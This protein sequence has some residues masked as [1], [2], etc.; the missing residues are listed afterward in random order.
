MSGC[1][2]DGAVHRVPN[3]EVTTVP[4]TGDVE[5]WRPAPL[6]WMPCDDAPSYDCATLEVPLD[7]NDPGGA[8]VPLAMTRARATGDRIGSLFMNPGGPGGSGIQ[9]LQAS[10]FDKRLT[11]RFD[12]VSWDPRGVGAS[13]GL[14][15]A[16]DGTVERF[17]ANDPSPDTIDEL[18]ALFGDAEAIARKCSAPGTPDAGLLT[19]IGTTDVARDLEA[20]RIAVGDERLTYLGFSYGTHI[21]QR[22]LQLY[23]E[24]VR[25]MVLDGVVDPTQS[26]TEWLRSQALAFEASLGRIFDDCDDACPLEDAAAAYDELHDR[27]EREPIAAGDDALGPARLETAAVYASYSP[28][29]WDRFLDGVADAL[30]GDPSTLLSLARQYYDFG[31]F[32]SYVSVV[33][34]DGEHPEGTDEYAAFIGDLATEAPRLGAMI[35]SELAACA[36]WPVEPDPITEP[37]TGE[38]APPVLVVGT[39]GDAATPYENARRVAHHLA[40]GVL[41]THVGEGHTAYGRESCV[42]SVVDD[43]LVDLVVPDRDPRCGG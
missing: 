20:M 14:T 35:A 1:G 9:F 19:H 21:G 39:T 18:E 40:S 23:P 41:V 25:A 43:Y 37:V 3:T 27:V 33:C 34:R 11:E 15:C 13:A 30:D 26:L 12:L 24:R 4:A 5:G 32:T 10:A 42:T 8:T 7:W 36:F 28:H 2:D 16:E 29:T 17:L 38:G 22:Y 6:S 31:G